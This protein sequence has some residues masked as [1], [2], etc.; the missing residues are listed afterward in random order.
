MTMEVISGPSGG[1]KS[2]TPIGGF[3]TQED[4]REIVAYAADRQIEVIPEIDVP[5]HSNSALANLK[6]TKSLDCNV[7]AILQFLGHNTND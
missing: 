1:I 2:G 3:Y 5:A 7:V 4:I 6:R